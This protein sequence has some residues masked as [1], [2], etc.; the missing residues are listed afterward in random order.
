MERQGPENQGH[1]Q[2]RKP[3]RE[4]DSA[5]FEQYR[6]GQDR[7]GSGGAEVQSLSA[8]NRFRPAAGSAAV[9][10]VGGA[11]AAGVAVDAGGSGQHCLWLGPGRDRAANG[12]SLSVHAERSE[13]RR[14]GKECRSRW[15][16][17]H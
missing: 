5:L 13:E 7:S 11:G 15:S 6:R 8:R 12:R 3:E 17:Y 10:R 2:I 14:V 9:G 4:Q 16:P 1:A